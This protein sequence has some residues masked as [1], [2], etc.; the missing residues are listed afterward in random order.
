MEKEW[1]PLYSYRCKKCDDTLQ[2]KYPGE[3]VMCSCEALY[4]D[5]TPYYV[6]IGGNMEDIEEIKNEDTKTEEG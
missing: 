4:V 5:Q 1:P 6:R 3:F 2:S